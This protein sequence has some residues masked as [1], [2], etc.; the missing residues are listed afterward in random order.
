MKPLCEGAQPLY[1]QRP[2]K[3]QGA[4]MAEAEEIVG[5][6]LGTAATRVQSRPAVVVPVGAR[7]SGACLPRTRG[8]LSDQW[9]P[10]Y[11]GPSA[12]AQLWPWAGGIMEALLTSLGKPT[13]RLPRIS[14][15]GHSLVKCQ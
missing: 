8:L 1:T 13:I 6:R 12:E 2:L 14:T 15:E 5:C 4:V 3:V 11:H 10:G 9:I 7:L